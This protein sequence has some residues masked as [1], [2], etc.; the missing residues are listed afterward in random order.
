VT[1][2]WIRATSP[3]CNCSNTWTVPIADGLV[4]PSDSG[5][6]EFNVNGAVK[7]QSSEEGGG[8]ASR[9]RPTER[10]DDGDPANG[11]F[12]AYPTC[13]AGRPDHGSNGAYPSWPAFAVEAL[14]YLD[15][16]FTSAFDI[17]ASF[18]PNT[19]EG[20]FGQAHEV[21]QLSTPPYVRPHSTCPCL[22]STVILVRQLSTPPCKYPCY[23]C[24]FLSSTAGA[25]GSSVVET[26]VHVSTL[27]SAIPVLQ[28]FLACGVDWSI[29]VVS[30]DAYTHALACAA[31]ILGASLSS[32]LLWLWSACS[33]AHVWWRS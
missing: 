8:D 25:A 17:F 26:T 15:G 2:S 4:R 33:L 21:P 10:N 16:N 24:P 22:S 12:P 29:V 32:A 30:R 9:E 7:H 23:T 1:S 14:G 18:E 3:R 6:A 13:S 20:P 5:V 11:P 27:H 31:C 19:H 28:Q